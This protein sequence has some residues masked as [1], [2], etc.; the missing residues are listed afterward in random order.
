MIKNE[1]IFIKVESLR[2]CLNRIKLKTPNTIFELQNN[3]DLQDILSINLERAIQNCVDIATHIIANSDYPAPTNMADSFTGLLKLNYINEKVS[4]AMIAAVG[5][6]N[7]AVHAYSD[8]DWEILFSIITQHLN[9]FKE[10]I[11]QILNN[12]E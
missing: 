4:K 10:F 5:F 12:I 7:I 2:R 3:Y 6:R 9:D 11:Q 8:I 1:L